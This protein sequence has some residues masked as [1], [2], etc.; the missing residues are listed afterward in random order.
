[1]CNAFVVSRQELRANLQVL[2]SPQSTEL[3]LSALTA[4]HRFFVGSWNMSGFLNEERETRTLREITTRLREAYCGSIGYE[5]MHIPDRDRCNWLRERIET[6]NKQKFSVEKQLHTYDRLAWSEI[7]ESFLA[8]KYAAA[9]RFG[10][11][12]CETLVPGMKAMIDTS[13][14]LGVETICL[15]MPHRGDSQ[16]ACCSSTMVWCGVPCGAHACCFTVT[17][18]QFGWQHAALLII[19]RSSHC[20]QYTCMSHFHIL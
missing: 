6:P 8:N 1:M 15:G 18:R 3:C 11:E 19:R 4:V 7:F 17:R 16:L 13:A 5:Y 12:G 2:P 20:S 14:D 10:L 9:K